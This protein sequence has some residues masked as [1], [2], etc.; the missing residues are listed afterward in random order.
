ME[1]PNTLMCEGRQ[2]YVIV[3][4]RRPLCWVCGAAGHLSRAWPGKTLELQPQPKNKNNSTDRHQ[5]K[6]SKK[7]ESGWKW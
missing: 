6:V 2:I 7:Q 4:G 5:Q 1:I 3:E